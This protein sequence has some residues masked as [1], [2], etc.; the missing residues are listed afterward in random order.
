MDLF[1]ICETTRTDKTFAISPSGSAPGAGGVA[2]FWW[3]SAN[4]NT[5]YSRFGPFWGLLLVVQI[6]KRLPKESVAEWESFF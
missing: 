6:Q 3:L 4:H 1:A 2:N 5:R